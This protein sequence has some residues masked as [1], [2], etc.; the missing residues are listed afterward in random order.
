MHRQHHVAD[1][2][3][4]RQGFGKGIHINDLFTF[5][6]AEQRGNGLAAYPEFAVVIVLNN[7]PSILFARPGKHLISSFYRHGNSGGKMVVGADVHHIR[8]RFS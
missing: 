6:D 8:L 1:S 5:I 7:V 4:G 3:G 2:D